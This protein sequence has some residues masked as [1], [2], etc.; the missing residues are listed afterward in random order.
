M[1]VTS[2]LISNLYPTSEFHRLYC[3]STL[4]TYPSEFQTLRLSKFSF[5]SLFHLRTFPIS[6]CF[7]LGWIFWIFP[8]FLRLK[9]SICYWGYFRLTWT[10][11]E[12]WFQSLL[13]LT[14]YLS[15][16]CY[17]IHIHLPSSASFTH[18]GNIFSVISKC[19]YRF[20]FPL[21]CQFKLIICYKVKLVNG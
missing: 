18:S 19:M 11:M 17:D 2:V 15:F 5:L 20:S 3:Q 12:L 10:L 6:S 14:L 1:L 7:H 4:N 9:V 13:S 16:F 21:H 8:R